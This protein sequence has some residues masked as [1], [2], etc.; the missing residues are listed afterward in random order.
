MAIE[1]THIIDVA[2]NTNSTKEQIEEIFPYLQRVKVSKEHHL[3]IERLIAVNPNT[4]TYILAYVFPDCCNEVLQN[5]AFEL[6]IL[7]NQ[8]LLHELFQGN[9]GIPIK[10]NLDILYKNHPLINYLYSYAI[11]EPEYQGEIHFI[12]ECKK[13]ILNSKYSYLLSE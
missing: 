13:S 10:L 4:P 8:N 6:L 11:K 1:L 9:C 2:T 3:Q 12:Q 5:P 7:E